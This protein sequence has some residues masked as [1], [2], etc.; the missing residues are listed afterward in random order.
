MPPLP[1][2]I[3]LAILRSVTVFVRLGIPDPEALV[4]R[5][6]NIPK[7]ISLYQFVAAYADAQGWDIVE[8]K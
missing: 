5:L 1:E 4:K 6:A 3:Y 2:D 8:Q 7:S